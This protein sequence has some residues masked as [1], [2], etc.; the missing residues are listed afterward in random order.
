[1]R[2]RDDIQTLR[3]GIEALR[4]LNQ[5]DS[6]S[7]S[8]IATALGMS[9]A[10]AYRVVGTLE[11]RG[12]LSRFG[13]SRRGRY[14]LAVGVCTLSDGFHGDR[15]LLQVAHPLLSRCTEVVGW[16]LALGVPAGD[17]SLVVFS[18]DHATSRLL[19][20]KR[21][22]RFESYL[23]SAIGEVCL[24]HL[25]EPLRSS[26]IQRLVAAAVPGEDLRT[27]A[28]A[29]VERAAQRVRERGFSLHEPPGARE[30][31]LAIPLHDRGRFIGALNMRYMRVAANGRTG[32]EQRRSA[33][34]ALACDI[35][36]E[37][38]GFAVRSAAALQ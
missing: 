36:R 11:A 7:C 22:G 12:H 10:A 27:N 31:D 17:R 18:T 37:L 26:C 32:H 24:A 1:M 34:M 29:S 8:E 28:A 33:L 6:A 15:A 9:R 14:R 21:A 13:L 4:L 30:L 35:Q 2:Q 25:P 23:A 3:W 16:P 20:R 19:T 38:Y 5:R